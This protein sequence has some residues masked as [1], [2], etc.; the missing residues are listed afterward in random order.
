M[1]GLISII[2]ATA[3]V[4]APAPVGAN[5]WILAPEHQELTLEVSQRGGVGYTIAVGP[6]G[7]LLRCE[8]EKTNRID[9]DVC[10]ILMRNARFLPAKDDQGNPIL[11]VHDGFANFAF[12]GKSQWRDRSKLAV[13][14]DRLPDGVNSPA[15]V[16][17]AFLVDGTGAISDCTAAAAERR[18]SAQNVGTLV[19]AACEKAV[20]D[21]RPAPAHNAAGEAARSVQTVLIRFETPQA[22]TQP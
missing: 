19:P 2:L 18:R 4:T 14:V 20:K 5:K 12:P 22:P 17:V 8:T 3:A 9:R 13:T 11:G 1:S 21:Y 6:D 15:F 7:A 16:K 10:R